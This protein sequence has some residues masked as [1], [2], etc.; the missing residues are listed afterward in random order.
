MN[1]LRA[2]GVLDRQSVLLIGD[3]V[4]AAFRLRQHLVAA[5]A[6]VILGDARETLPYLAAPA[7]A[8][9]VVA[10]DVNAIDRVGLVAALAACPAPWVVYGPKAP[11]EVVAAADA[12]ITNDPGLLV[13][14]LAAWLEPTHH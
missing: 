2:R 4:L 13:A 9:V 10:A 1:P 7:L 3:D 8:A 5:G 11:A 6:R 14:T 12:H